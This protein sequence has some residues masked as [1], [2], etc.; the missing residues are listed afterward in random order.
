MFTWTGEKYFFIVS[1]R[2]RETEV[3]KGKGFEIALIVISFKYFQLGNSE[4]NHIFLTGIF[5]LLSSGASQ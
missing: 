2:A 4:G 5:P 1:G 3:L